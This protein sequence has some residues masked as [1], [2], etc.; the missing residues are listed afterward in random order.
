MEVVFT[1]CF[2]N[3]IPALHTWEKCTAT[4]SSCTL[5]PGEGRRLP[6]MLCLPFNTLS[7]ATIEPAQ[8]GYGCLTMTWD[9]FQSDKFKIKW[10]KPSKVNYN[11]RRAWDKVEFVCTCTVFTGLF[12]FL[13]ILYLSSNKSICKSLMFLR[14]K[15]RNSQVF[16]HEYV[17]R[18]YC[19][20][21]GC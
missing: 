3:D 18:W 13:Y 9:Q 2:S 7:P 6:A 12:V 11:D 1:E 10:F 20:G 14:R 17:Q 19:E 21:L 4:S 5:W 8:K 15:E 16:C